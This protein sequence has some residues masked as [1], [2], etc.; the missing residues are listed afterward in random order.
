MLSGISLNIFIISLFSL[1][2]PFKNVTLDRVKTFITTTIIILDFS[3]PNFII[4]G[5]KI[6]GSTNTYHCKHGKDDSIF[7]SCTKP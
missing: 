6:D 5:I 2:M 4:K 3:I 7:Y 1:K